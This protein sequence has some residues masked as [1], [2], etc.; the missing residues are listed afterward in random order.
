MELQSVTEQMR[1]SK[2]KLRTW[3]W[4]SIKLVKSPLHSLFETTQVAKQEALMKLGY[5]TEEADKPEAATAMLSTKN[6]RKH[7]DR[8]K[9]LDRNYNLGT[10]S[11][12]SEDMDNDD[13]PKKKNG[14]M[15]KKIGVL[16]K[17]GQK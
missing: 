12:L 1:C 11:P 17:K 3:K 15:L 2:W 8:T 10:G 5:L 7:S 14:N 6:N 13:S 9:S 4:M 16:W